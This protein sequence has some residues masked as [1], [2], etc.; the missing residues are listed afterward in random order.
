[1]KQVVKNNLKLILGMAFIASIILYAVMTP[2]TPVSLFQEEELLID[3]P[4]AFVTNA[5]YRTFDVKGNLT[6]LLHSERAKHFPDTDIGYLT[7]PDLKLFQEGESNWHAQSEEG[8]FD[9]R[10]DHLVLKGNVVI[11]GEN[12]KGQPFTM[13]TDRLNYANKSDFIETDQP[14]KIVSSD[15]EITAVGMTADITEKKI[16]LLSKVKGHYVQP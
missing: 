15:S 6:S 4:D 9:V 14:V 7:L 13:T 16:N 3:E 12:R 1:M 10:N 5:V 8:E 11:L 2:N